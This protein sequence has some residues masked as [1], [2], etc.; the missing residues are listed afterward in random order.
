MGGT[1]GETRP[2]MANSEL[3]EYGIFQ[4]A[5]H[6]TRVHVS[7]ATCCVYVFKAAEA[8]TACT[9][10]SFRT[11]SAYQKGIETARGFLVPVSE[12][13]K[14]EKYDIPP[15][16]CARARRYKNAT[17]S[18]KGEVAVEI[19]KYMVKTGVIPIALSIEEIDDEDMQVSGMDLTIKATVHIQVKCDWLAGDKDKGGTGNLFIQT[20]ECNP[21]KMY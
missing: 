15:A 13:E 1:P 14:L 21:F 5:P 6:I 17:T 19:V 11:R 8:Q 2:I 12:I 18:K 3:V 9:E 4:E 7:L 20:H 16:W 10:K